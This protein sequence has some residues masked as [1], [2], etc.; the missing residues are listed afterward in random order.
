M[1]MLDF[2]PRVWSAYEHPSDAIWPADSDEYGICAI[3]PLGFLWEP[4][5]GL[6]KFRTGVGLPIIIA[7]YLDN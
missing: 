5:N 6:S 4:A 1:V 7:T 2:M 3:V